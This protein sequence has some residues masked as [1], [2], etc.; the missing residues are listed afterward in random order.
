MDNALINVITGPTFLLGHVAFKNDLLVM[1]T[2]YGCDTI[3]VALDKLGGVVPNFICNQTFD[4]KV[5]IDGDAFTFNYGGDVTLYGNVTYL[6][7]DTL[8]DP[9]LAVD[10]MP[11]LKNTEY[12]RIEEWL[13]SYCQSSCVEMRTFLARRF[14]PKTK[15]EITENARVFVI[16]PCVC[17]YDD[18]EVQ[19][20]FHPSTPDIYETD[21]SDDE[22]NKQAEI[23]SAF[24]TFIAEFK[25]FMYTSGI[26]NVIV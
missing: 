18:N 9:K 11:E 6:S 15:V 21:G 24:K 23:V 12:T 3:Q 26:A 5:K 20:S 2:M 8:R 10:Q 13:K 4:T 16:F 22:E 17:G 7:S 19:F 25:A 14:D 1:G